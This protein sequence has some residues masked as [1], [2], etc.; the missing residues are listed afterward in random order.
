MREQEQ[1]GSTLMHITA[2]RRE[3]CLIAPQQHVSD[4]QQDCR[5]QHRQHRLMTVAPRR[6]DNQ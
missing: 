3:S 2:G 4:Q 6:T 1:T 5:R